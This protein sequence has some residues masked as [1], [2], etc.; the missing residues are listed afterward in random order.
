MCS[1]RAWRA[2]DV[3]LNPLSVD[4]MVRDAMTVAWE[5]EVDLIFPP[6][7]LNRCAFPRQRLLRRAWTAR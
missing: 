1:I 4:E 7:R 3:E 6:Y 5:H 2:S